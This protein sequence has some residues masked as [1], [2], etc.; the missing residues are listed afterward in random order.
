MNINIEDKNIH[1]DI[2]DKIDI[3]L[4]NKL[5]QSLLYLNRNKYVFECFRNV[6]KWI[7]I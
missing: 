5:I 2:N 6:Q 4:K 7:L 1:D 3:A